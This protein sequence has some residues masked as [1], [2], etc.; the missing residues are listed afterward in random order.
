[1]MLQMI[2]NGIGYRIC[3][4]PILVLSLKQFFTFEVEC[5]PFV[6]FF[7]YIM[8][9][10]CIQPLHTIHYPKKIRINKEYQLLE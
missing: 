6:N 7:P 9:F 5:I 2:E 4:Q 3:N 1:M 8:V 10:Y